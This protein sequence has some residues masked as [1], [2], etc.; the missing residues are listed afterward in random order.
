M[1]HRDWASFSQPEKQAFANMVA[2]TNRLEFLEGVVTPPHTVIDLV[3]GAA[4][5]PPL[6]PQASSRIHGVPPLRTIT[7]LPVMTPTGHIAVQ[8][9]PA[10]VIGDRGTSDST[11]RNIVT[12][13][14]IL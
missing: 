11:S 9:P 13:L 1:P 4:P 12:C 8:A 10:L 14:S 3:D 6:L 7:P 5:P 2:N